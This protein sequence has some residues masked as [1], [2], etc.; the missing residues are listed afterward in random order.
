[1]SNGFIR[2]VVVRE[3]QQISCHQQWVA[4]SMQRLIHIAACR[5]QRK[6]ARTSKDPSDLLPPSRPHLPNVKSHFQ[7]VK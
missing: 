2:S 7:T 1:M 3:T 4:R 5:K 6:Q